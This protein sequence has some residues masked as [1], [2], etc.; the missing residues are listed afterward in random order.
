MKLDLD[1]YNTRIKS[2][3]KEVLTDIQSEAGS[4][5]IVHRDDSP[6]KGASVPKMKDRYRSKDGAV[7]KISFAFRRTLIYTHK[8][9]GKGRGGVKGSK[10]LDKFGVTKSTKD[11]SKGL[12]GTGG[13]KEKPFINKVLEQ[14]GNG[15]DK[16]AAIAAEELGDA[17]VNNMLVK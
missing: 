1:R 5:A 4:M 6:S 17:I 13:R 14:E 7:N 10:W 15:V 11:S 12:A 9:A 2:A 8:G 16:L 3:G